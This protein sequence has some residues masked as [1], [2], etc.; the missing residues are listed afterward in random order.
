MNRA[1]SLSHYTD[2]IAIS[3]ICLFAFFEAGVTMC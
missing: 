2:Q 1:I 3:N